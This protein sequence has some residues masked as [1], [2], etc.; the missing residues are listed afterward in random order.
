LGVLNRVGMYEKRIRVFIAASLLLLGIGALRLVQMQLL[1]DSSLRDEITA[2]KQQGGRSKQFKTLRGQ[3]LDRNGNVLATDTPRFQI[4]IDY[5]LTQFSDRRVINAKRILVEG[6]ANPSD[7]YE[8]YEEVLSRQEDIDRIILDCTKFGV[9]KEE[10]LARIERMNDKI[11]N[12]RTFLAWYRS[13]PDPNL[14]AKYDGRINS[15]PL[16]EARADLQ[17]RFP[18]PNQRR[19]LIIDVDD[20]RDMYEQ[21]P[22]LELKT[23]DDI[24]AAQI[25]FM[26]IND[27][28]IVPKGQREYPYGSV[29]AQTIGWVGG[30]TQDRDKVLFK[31]DPLASYLEGEICG[32]RPGVEYVCEPILRGRRGELVQDID[33]QLVRRTETEFGHD[34]Q[35]TLDIELQRRIEEYLADPAQNAN[36]DANMAAVV[37]EIRSG[38]I[39]A[40]VSLPTFN[41]NR[42]RYDYGKLVADPNHPLLNRAIAKH[43]LPGSAVKP[44]ILIA[45]METGV[46][47]PDRIIHC[48]AEDAP[49][50]WPNCHIWKQSHAG[51]DWQWE[52][53]ARNAIKGS[54]NIY[55]SH[56]ANDVE[57]NDLQ[58]WLFSF[59]YGHR[60]PLASP[61]PDPNAALQRR[62]RQVPGQI[63][64]T[65]VA[66]RT[67]IESLEDLP[68]LL[69]RDRPLFG[70]GHGNFW[71]TPLQVANSFATL[72]RGGLST[73]PR[74]FLKPTVLAPEEVR[75]PVD[76]QISNLTLQTLYDG[77]DAVVNEPGGTA[78]KEFRTSDLAQ[79]GVK[80]LGK[81]G[82]TERPY[83]ACFA[84]FAE[85]HEGA[86][87]AVAIVVEGGAHGSSDAAPLA[88]GIIDLCVEMGYVGAA[89]S[90]SPLPSNPSN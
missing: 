40:L 18:D 79:Q 66:E 88:R 72:A 89:T 27:V 87:V 34:V 15:I 29:A 54:C 48:R 63:S 17:K 43:Y 75:E 65:F 58:R 23:K 51:H 19:K 30:A 1:A 68:P 32:R 14:V 35:L 2:L 52:N 20:V 61:L 46:T 3:V 85:D 86:K 80:V 25:E 57:P 81:T 64:S 60:L 82:S 12:L 33:G 8:L 59:G 31:N 53:N 39:L 70:I 16:S 28:N 26:D 5:Q 83:N 6:N 42:A 90:A 10:I 73:P 41:C 38:D 11:W 37:I 74:L 67:R 69:K 44:I 36:A 77:M 55:F 45:G 84:G 9:T 76:L 71:A 56:V 7:E 24:F 13:G 47:T 4:A 49:R 22:L 21:Q 62:L 78:Y 50:G